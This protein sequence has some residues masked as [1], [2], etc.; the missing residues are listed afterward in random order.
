MKSHNKFDDDVW[1]V[2]AETME[3]YKG[4]YPDE[5]VRRI[6]EESVI[7]TP[8]K[9]GVFVSRDNEFDLFVIPEMRGK[10]NIKREFNNFI[11]QMLDKYDSLVCEISEKNDLSLR[12]A[13]FFGFKE[14]SLV[15]GV[16]KLELRK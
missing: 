6:V 4:I 5:K 7:I 8:F 12:V 15:D 1:Q 13:K 9:G 2:I 16:V 11:N 10:W 14:I 3:E